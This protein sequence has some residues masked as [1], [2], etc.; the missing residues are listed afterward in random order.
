MEAGSVTTTLR[1]QGSSIGEIIM[2]KVKENPKIKLNEIANK[3]K[4]EY[5][6]EVKYSK[7]RRAREYGHE[8]LL[9][10]Y[11]DE[12]SELAFKC[13]KLMEVNSGSVA[14][15]STDEGLCLFV[16]FNAS[17]SRFIKGCR[18]FLFLLDEENDD[19]WRWFLTKLKILVSRHGPITFVMI[20]DIVLVI[21]IVIIFVLISL[22]L[23]LLLLLK[24]DLD[25]WLIKTCKILDLVSNHFGVFGY[26]FLA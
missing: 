16:A 4:G 14:K 17:I 10:S 21:T 12:N 23:L 20:T 9:G 8:Q 15:F 1:A 18:S 2:E 25:S 5:G 13:E 3:I 11:N 22:V 26:E 19:N 24:D 6:V 7:E